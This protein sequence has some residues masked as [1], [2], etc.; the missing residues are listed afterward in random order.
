MNSNDDRVPR[1]RRR[2]EPEEAPNEYSAQSPARPRRR[3]SQAARLREQAEA[4][5]AYEPSDQEDFDEAERRYGRPNARTAQRARTE[6]APPRRQTRGYEPDMDEAEEDDYYD[7]EDDVRA[8]GE[9]RHVGR[10][11]IV[12]VV[13]LAL[14]GGATFVGLR[15]PEWVTPVVQPIIELFVGATPTP[16]PTPTPTPTPVPEP[17]ATP[18]PAADAAVVVGFLA[19][20]A[21]LEDLNSPVSFQITTSAQTDRVRIVDGNGQVLIE[22]MEGD[23]TDTDAGRIWNMMVYFTEPYEGMVEAYPG[24]VSGWN[25]AK[26]AGIL[27]KV[28]AATPTEPPVT[29]TQAPVT[30]PIAPQLDPAPVAEA[31]ETTVTHA[32]LVNNEA[33]DAYTNENAINIPDAESYARPGGVLTFRGSGMRQNAAYGTIAPAEQMMEIAWT[34]ETSTAVPEGEGWL[35]QPLIIQW[36]GDVRALLPL[37]EEKAEKASLKEVIY[38]A[39]DGNIYFLDLEDGSATR[40]PL[41]AGLPLS[42]SAS[43]YPNGVP[44]LYVG[45]GA[46]DTAADQNPGLYLYNLITNTQFGRIGGVNENAYADNAAFYGSVI[47]D[48][49]A[50]TSFSVAG[51]GMLN[52]LTMEIGF[53]PSEGEIE[54]LASPSNAAYLSRAGEEDASVPGGFAAYGQYAYFANAGGVLQCVDLNTLSPVW[55][56]NLGVGTT[57]SPALEADASGNTALYI[58]SL[59]DANG[60]AHLY[61][62]DAATGE[63]VWNVTVLGDVIASPLV[64][65]ED[66]AGTIV[67][68]TY[69]TDANGTVYALDKQTGDILWELALDAGAVASPVALYG[70]N[71]EAWVMAADTAGMVYLLNAADGTICDK[72]SLEGG[73]VGSLV[74]YD[75]T[76][77]VALDNGSLCAVRIR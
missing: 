29:A 45:A 32:L 16:A 15:H 28:G 59:A 64:G 67:F 48:K 23:Y 61:R 25:E 35:L 77:V 19:D 10:W 33:A 51:N 60:S 55:A 36:D 34:A 24:N 68:V 73:A 30:D 58:A 66:I 69:D 13:I 56:L 37:E 72:I 47:V 11:I 12:V 53:S 63:V 8:R 6:E 44:L 39:G 2:S 41:A 40:D 21:E 76:I 57:S 42:G 74:A 22:G 65:A 9:K 70:E 5:Y 54:L 1:A 27:I 4:E 26:G 18:A 3:R 62:V 31:E 50:A 20:P 38:P 46:A 75:A 49:E 71:G 7:D 17:T 14:L 52:A 43:L